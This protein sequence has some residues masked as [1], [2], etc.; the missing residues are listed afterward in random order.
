MKKIIA[1]VEARLNSKRLPNKVLKKI[2]NKELIRIIIERLRL[3][4]KLNQIVVA[5]TIS[6]KDNKLVNF[7]K[8]I[9]I[10]FFRLSENI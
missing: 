10:K 8:K 2:K 7:L 3:S 9:K 4:K 5:T 6:K 1:I